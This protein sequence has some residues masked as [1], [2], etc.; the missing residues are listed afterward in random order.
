MGTNFYLIEATEEDILSYSPE[1][2]IGKRSGAGPYC[3]DCNKTLC[4]H[5]NEG[6]HGGYAQWHTRCPDCGKEPSLEEL[7]ESTGGR[8]LGFNKNPPAKK[9]G[10]RSCCSFTWAMEQERVQS[11]PKTGKVI[12]DEYGREY[13]LQDF[14]GVL[15]ECPVNFYNSVGA[16]FA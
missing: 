2:H 9:T 1:F 6:L 12:K 10:V 15:E 11:L 14:Q 3:W 16:L 7:T 8:K 13:T 5:G 4:M